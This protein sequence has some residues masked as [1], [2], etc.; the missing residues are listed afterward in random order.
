MSRDEIA[1][2]VRSIKDLATVVR[3]AEPEDKA[4]IYRQLGLRLTYGSGKHKVLAEMRLDQHSREARGP[5]ARVR[6]PTRTIRT[7]RCCG[8]S[9]SCRSPRVQAVGGA[10]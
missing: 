5:S 9:C 7:R 8:A 6:G 10:P 4:E 1:R 2:L 3:Q